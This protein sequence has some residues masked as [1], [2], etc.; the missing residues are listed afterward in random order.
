LWNEYAQKIGLDVDRFQSDMAGMITKE[1]VRL[2]LERGRGLGVDS[3]PTVFV[4]GRP[5]PFQEISVGSMRRIID[6]E[7]QNTS[8]RNQSPAAAAN[9]GNSSAA[10]GN[11]SNSSK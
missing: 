5:V 11:A 6:A 10:A 9:S 4:N 1:R 2:D 3:T 7:I 8:A